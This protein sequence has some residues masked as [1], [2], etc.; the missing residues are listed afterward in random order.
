[1]VADKG[2]LKA[3]GGAVEGTGL[4]LRGPRAC[5]G[6]VVEGGV[7][8][9]GTDIGAGVCLSASEIEAEE[10]GGVVVVGE[11]S[12]V[13]GV[14]DEPEACAS[15]FGARTVMVDAR[16][17]VPS[18]D[19][20]RCPALTVM[21]D[22]RPMVDLPLIVASC[23][24]GVEGMKS[25]ASFSSLNSGAV[26]SSDVSGVS[27][28]ASVAELVSGDMLGAELD[29]ETSAGEPKV[30]GSALATLFKCERGRIRVGLSRAA[31]F[32]LGK[33]SMLLRVSRLRRE[34]ILGRSS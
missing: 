27:V 11:S 31:L 5:A 2:A 3:V 24:C 10:V 12:G 21:M 23:L 22:A 9:E 33:P 25:S 30:S 8:V 18:V 26:D 6:V 14:E 4:D 32:G 29:V 15:N 1:M 19:S 7:A 17:T 16:V 20:G 28:G 13:A 34:S